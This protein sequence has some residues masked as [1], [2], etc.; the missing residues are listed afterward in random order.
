VL[1]MVDRTRVDAMLTDHCRLGM[2]GPM[3]STEIWSPFGQTVTVP[4]RAGG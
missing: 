2:W 4:D 3:E 1:P